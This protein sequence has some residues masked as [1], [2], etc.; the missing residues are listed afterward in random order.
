MKFQVGFARFWSSGKR[1]T[2]DRMLKLWKHLFPG[3]FPSVL[4]IYL[5]IV[6]GIGNPF[7]R[8]GE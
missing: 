6:F 2:R 8:L 1:F 4:F 7:S 3:M 5:F